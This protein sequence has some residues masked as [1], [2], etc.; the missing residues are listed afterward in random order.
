MPAW[1]ST[2][3]TLCGCTFLHGM[4]ITLCHTRLAKLQLLASPIRRTAL[5]YHHLG[6]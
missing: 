5:P 3:V 6:V 2:D 4:P 1:C